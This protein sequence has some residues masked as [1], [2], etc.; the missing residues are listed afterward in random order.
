[1]A[2]RREPTAAVAVMLALAGVPAFGQTPGGESSGSAIVEEALKGVRED[3]ARDSARVKQIIDEAVRGAAGA[4]SGQDT[5]N[6]TAP[7]TLRILAA[8][9]AQR[10]LPIG[11]RA[12][13]LLGSPVGDGTGARIGT[14]RDLVRDDRTGVALAMVEFAPLFGGPGKTS[15]VAI[16]S[17]TAAGARG[18]GYV[19]E[20]TTVDYARLPA[21]E[22]DEE[23]WRRR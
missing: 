3:Q 14:V 1:M 22:R 11:V 13:D 19:M 17:L 16:E 15:V 8:A 4:P 5:V 20:L 6:P 10:D 2:K 7:E 21:Y 9:D 12:E 23:L 18:A